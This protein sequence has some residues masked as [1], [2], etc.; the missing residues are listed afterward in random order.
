MILD[1]KLMSGGNQGTRDF[2]WQA[3][4]E[5]DRATTDFVH[6][7]SGR[8]FDLEA[9]PSKLLHSAW[10]ISMR[11]LGCSTTS[12]AG[13]TCAVA[14]DAFGLAEGD[15]SSDLSVDGEVA[16]GLRPF[17]CGVAEEKKARKK[18]RTEASSTTTR[19]QESGQ[20]NSTVSEGDASSSSS[21]PE[22]SVGAQ[23]CDSELEELEQCYELFQPLATDL[24]QAQCFVDTKAREYKGAKHNNLH[25]FL[26]LP[27]TWPLA[28]M[29]VPFINLIK[30]MESVVQAHCL[31][32]I[33]RCKNPWEH[34]GHAHMSFFC[35]MAI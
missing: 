5:G 29:T 18:A 22:S 9:T 12:M 33:A 2:R 30:Q 1:F 24:H 14:E 25:R 34:T 4:L 10:N 15:V 16:K 13:M 8:Y 26:R 31:Q 35:Q 17:M 19:G 6:G 21:E 7:V 23:N 3:A 27:L 11:P 28:R 32:T 20:I